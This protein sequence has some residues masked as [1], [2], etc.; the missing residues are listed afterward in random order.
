MNHV[1]R[2]LKCS[3]KVSKK[4]ESHL[5]R[6]AIQKKLKPSN[7]GPGL[8]VEVNESMF[9]RRKYPQRHRVDGQW[10][11]VGIKAN[12]KKSFF[13]S[14]GRSEGVN[15]I[16]IIKDLIK[17]VFIIRSD[18]W[19]GYQCLQAEDYT[20]EVVNHCVAFKDPKTGAHTNTIEFIWQL[21]KNLFFN[22]RKLKIREIAIQPCTYFIN[23]QTLKIK[24]IFFISVKWQENVTSKRTI[25]D[26]IY[27]NLL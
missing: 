5:N 22:T 27:N 20:H 2:R 9:G 8:I 11:F 14:S 26:Y 10:V 7:Q 4:L 25:L 17:L 16:I 18:G 12:T 15:L 23:T 24:I 19:A 21:V 6:S 1:S 3:A 13:Y